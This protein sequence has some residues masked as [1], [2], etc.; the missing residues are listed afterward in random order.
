MSSIEDTT[1]AVAK[2]LS[3]LTPGIF[4]T[5][6]S[7]LKPPSQASKEFWVVVFKRGDLED[8]ELKGVGTAH[9]KIKSVNGSHFQV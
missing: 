6:L 8:F 1:T 7:D 9:Y 5:E 2:M 4:T 3:N